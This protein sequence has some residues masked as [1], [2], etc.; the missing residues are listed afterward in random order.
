MSDDEWK[1]WP[2]DVISLSMGDIPYNHTQVWI[3]REGHEPGTIIVKTMDPMMNVNGLMWKPVDT[4]WAWPVG[5]QQ[6]A[7]ADYLNAFQPD[8][9]L[10]KR[11]HAAF[12]N[13]RDGNGYGGFGWVEQTDFMRALEELIDR[14]VQ[15]AIEGQ[16][17]K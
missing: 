16:G 9:D 7:A 14:R 12:D 8:Q 6:E 17:P 5:S 10:R 15:R 2:T 4:K 1:P 13:I 3:K 11:M